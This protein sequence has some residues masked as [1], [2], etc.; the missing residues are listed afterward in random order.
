MSR[1]PEHDPLGAK[2]VL[3][4]PSGP[5]A[6]RA[7]RVF[8]GYVKRLRDGE[9]LEELTQA[10]PM[11]D[12]GPGPSPDVSRVDLL[13]SAAAA[14]A[15][16]R[17]Y[18]LALSKVDSPTP[19]TGETEACFVESTPEPED[20]PERPPPGVPTVR[21]A[22]IRKSR[23]ETVP[24]DLLEGTADSALLVADPEGGTSFEI[25]FNED[26]FPNLACR[27]TVI[28]GKV[29]ATFRVADQN[30]RRLLEAEAGRLRASL[31]ERGLKVAEVKV[32][33]G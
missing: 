2:P 5:G 13:P 25:A 4:P 16:G 6:A 15:S 18:D 33:V 7:R 27:I 19:G 12:P 24:Q 10:G 11:L 31:E 21:P 14:A 22:V 20:L 30:L 32:E 28:G 26:V 1:R 23:P 9:S 29:I 17:H 3:P 8:E